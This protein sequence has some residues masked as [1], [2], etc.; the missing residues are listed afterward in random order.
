MQEQR[1]CLRCL[2]KVCQRLHENRHPSNHRL[3]VSS[4]SRRSCSAI[5][6]CHFWSH[7]ICLSP[8]LFDIFSSQRPLTLPPTDPLSPHSLLFCAGTVMFFIVRRQRKRQR[9][10]ELA[11]ERMI[12]D[13]M[14]LTWVP[15]PKSNESNWPPAQAPNNYRDPSMPP[16][17]Y[18][19][20][21]PPRGHQKD[22][23][24][25]TSRDSDYA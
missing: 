6:L 14:E 13:N 9:A 5:L 3:I 25:R 24:R 4:H 19:Q 18:N 16:P 1:P 7:A 10:A 8:F 11:K 15:I 17:S 2:R 12:D 21:Y 23:G 20:A 22:R